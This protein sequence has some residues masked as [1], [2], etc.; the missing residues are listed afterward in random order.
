MPACRDQIEGA[1][2]LRRNDL[3]RSGSFLRV[4]HSTRRILR[5]SI[6]CNI[7]ALMPRTHGAAPSEHARHNFTA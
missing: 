5:R 2:A 4:I 1:L 6:D 7:S 3:D